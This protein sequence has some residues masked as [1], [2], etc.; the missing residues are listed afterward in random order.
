MTTLTSTEVIRRHAYIPVILLAIV[1]GLILAVYSDY[2]W[3]S[4]LMLGRYEYLPLILALFVPSAVSFLITQLKSAIFYINILLITLLCVWLS[5]WQAS[6]DFGLDKASFISISSALVLIFLLLPWLQMR[7]ITGSWR[8][9]YACL[10]GFYAR[11]CSTGVLAC[12]IG[13]LLV[14]VALLAGFL[15]DSVNF[16]TLS[17]ILQ[18][19]PVRWL[20]FTLGFNISL[21]FMRS[22]FDIQL[23]RIFSLVARFFLPLFSA[24]S[25]IFLA[26]FFFSKLTGGN[27]SGL[28]S[29]AM[30]W[31]LILSIV[32][33]NLVYEDGSSRYQFRPWLNAFVLIGILLLNIFAWLSL[34]GIAVRVAQ[35]SWSVERLYAMTIALFLSLVIGAYSVAILL[36]RTAWMQWIGGINK[37]ALLTLMATILL[38]NSPIADFNRIALNSIMS[39]IESGKIKVDY[40]LNS[41]LNS[42]GSHGKEAVAQL[43]KNPEYAEL[44]KKYSYAAEPEEPK[45]S[46]KEVL[47]IAENSQPL[48]DSWQSEQNDEYYCTSRRDPYNCIGFMLDVNQDGHDEVVMC[49]THQQSTTVECKIWQQ[50]QDTWDFIESQ[51]L[52]FNYRTERDQAWDKIYQGKVHLQVKTWQALSI[53]Q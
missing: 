7:Q 19:A 13:G 44:L 15:F 28:G 17:N 21:V 16:H 34:Y 31:F 10:I 45:K 38:I 41:T 47:V 35:Y 49:M 5:F 51:Y 3:R 53:D 48:P 26:G 40:Y 6:Y 14:C 32:L 27:V 24:V 43:Q 42:L 33:L 1:Q 8:A 4:N 22:V 2:S 9:D 25:V 36:K 12:A 30:I 18:S 50:K 29:F 23:S 37:I 52:H 11:N 20:L 39:G 46:L